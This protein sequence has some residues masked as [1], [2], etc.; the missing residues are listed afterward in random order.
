M[1]IMGDSVLSIVIASLAGILTDV[2]YAWLRPDPEERLTNYRLFAMCAPMLLFLVYFLV[3]QFATP[4]GV[5]WT[6]HLSAGSIVVS[7]LLGLLLTYLIKPPAI[8]QG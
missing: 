2:A 5:I 6:I 4:T 8:K 1:A 7:G 3:L